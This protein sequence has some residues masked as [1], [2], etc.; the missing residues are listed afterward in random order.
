M[1]PRDKIHQQLYWLLSIAIVVSLPFSLKLCSWS[2]GLLT[3]NWLVEGGFRRKFDIIKSSLFLKLIIL[4]A[5]L[6]IVSLIYSTDLNHGMFVLEIK[7]AIL[8][9]PIVIGTIPKLSHNSLRVVLVSFIV[10]CAATAMISLSLS[11]FDQPT[12]D[13]IYT[14]FD[15]ITA[16][17]YTS[18][19]INSSQS[20][21]LFSYVGLSHHINLH[22]TYFSMYL[23]F[24]ICLIV[25]LYRDRLVE[26]K[27][28]SKII[29]SSLVG[30]FVITI[31]L[32]SSRI[33]IIAMILLLL[34]SIF[35]YFYRVKGYFQGILMSI[36]A[37]LI[38]S[39]VIYQ[40]P[41]TRYRLIQEPLML[42]NNLSENPDWN[43][44]SLRI[45]EWK[46][47]LNIIKDNSII[48]VGI[49]DIRNALNSQYHRMADLREFDINLNS[50]NQ[51]LQ[52]TATLGILGLS[53]LLGIII[54][55][56]LAAYKKKEYL[57][58]TY[59]FIFSICF[60]T[61]S[62]LEVQK[63]IV[64]FALFHSLLFFHPAVAPKNVANE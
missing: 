2:I 46:A 1:K 57:Y 56:A 37:L 22:P 26:M 14:N 12:A 5:L 63:G 36:S 53:L 11:F 13:S 17:K 29:L 51:Y 64:F 30:L 16:E 3:L 4:F 45:L 7:L 44:V 50:H 21:L 48:G 34:V 49:G 33:V 61:E 41:V 31:M 42:E 20:W 47:S 40:N 60:L 27:I 52:T 10:S 9:L 6:H 8:V 24:S 54:Y 43:S 28:L 55:P 18:Q 23:L 32:L 39:V 35:R 62:M 58:L 38:I 19:F 25:F 59:I 15:H